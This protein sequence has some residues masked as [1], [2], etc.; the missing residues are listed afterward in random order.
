[1]AVFI[2]A[3][4]DEAVKEQFEKMCENKGVTPP[5]VI[6]MFIANAVANNGF[7]VQAWEALDIPQK[8]KKRRKMT[9]E[10]MF[11]CMKGQFEM[12]DDFDAPLE[13]FKEYME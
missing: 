13:D 7:H 5:D 6:G 3:P 11:G 4:V 8:T 12:A 1:M 10:E 9:R 2:S